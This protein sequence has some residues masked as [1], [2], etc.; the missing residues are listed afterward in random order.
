MAKPKNHVIYGDKDDLLRLRDEYVMIGRETKL[1]AD[2]LI[3]FALPQR[4]Q[5]KRK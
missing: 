5:A 3:I 4:R 1:E 2:R